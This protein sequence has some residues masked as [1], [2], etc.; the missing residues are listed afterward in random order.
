MWASVNQAANT[1]SEEIINPQSVEVSGVIHPS[2]IFSTWSA[3]ELKDI[4]VYSMTVE[5]VNTQYYNVDWTN[6]TYTINQSAGSVIKH[7]VKVEKD[8]EQAKTDLIIEINER[9]YTILLQ[10]DWQMTRAWESRMNSEVANTTPDQTLLDYRES[11]RTSADAKVVQIAAMIN[12]ANCVNFSTTS[13][14]PASNT[15]I[16]EPKWDKILVSERDRINTILERR[17]AIFGDANTPF[18]PSD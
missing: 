18:F 5:D 11:V 7:P 10:S 4:G 6:P 12:I 16:Y 2:Q 3:G 8:L 13:N 9:A 1:V 15:S 14:W 17:L